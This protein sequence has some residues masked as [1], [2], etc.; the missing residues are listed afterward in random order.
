[1]TIT[2]SGPGGISVD[3]PDG[4]DSD[5]ISKVMQEASGG[6]AP[7]T[8]RDDSVEGQLKRAFD[9]PGMQKEIA[10]EGLSSMSQGIQQ[11]RDNT[12]GD[13]LASAGATLRGLGN[14]AGGAVQY[15]GSPVW[16]GTRLAVGRP[17]EALG[18]PKEYSEFAANLALPLPKSAPRL[19]R[20]EGP[21]PTTEELRNAY[22]A[23]KESPEVA[24]VKIRPEATARNSE[25]TAVALDKEWLDRNLAPGTFKILDKLDRTQ[26]P[27]FEMRGLESAGPVERTAAPT[28]MAEID[29]ARRL[30]GRKAA[31]GDEEAVAAQVAK[32]KLDEWLARGVSKEETLAGNPEVA[33]GIMQEGR[34]NYRGL[35]AAEALD[36][37]VARAELQAAAANSGLNLQNRLRS[38][39]GQLLMSDDAARLPAAQKEALEQFV[40]GSVPQNVLRYAGNM[41]GGGGG[42]AAPATA[43]A[44]KI[45]AGNAGGLLP[46]GGLGLNRLSAALTSRQANKLSEMI[47][48]DTPLGRQ[49]RGP[50]DDWNVAVGEASAAPTARNLSRLF[51]ASRNLS[52][53]LKDA[54]IS[55]SPDSLLKTIYKPTEELDTR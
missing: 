42:V 46:L 7:A 43:A 17:L 8:T 10:Q 26:A 51:I 22:V 39:V 24:A 48:S 53:N 30:L 12:G 13:L 29:S 33:Q 6:A 2:V 5:T 35:K 21:A 44:G 45:V 54:G 38:N 27:K 23:A 49:M 3:F 20:A 37:R 16:A 40:R 25:A 55:V 41:L 28:S 4:T 47:R 52:N 50:M 36:S 11:L 31:G 1:M 18:I 19:A 9:Y 32:K 14:L 34:E 15:A